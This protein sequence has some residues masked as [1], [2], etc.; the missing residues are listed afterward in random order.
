MEQRLR[1]VQGGQARSD[2]RM[3]DRRRLAVPGQIV[4]KDARGTTRMAAVVTRDVSENGVS[5]DCLGGMPIPL[6][7][8]VYFQIDREARNRPDLPAALRK[9]SVLSAIFRVGACKQSTGAPSEYALRM[10]VEPE[11]VVAAKP[12]VIEP[13]ETRTA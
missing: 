12:V 4:W 13:Q 3:S 9:S 1:L 11:R 10:L 7:S 8:L 5:V 6:F 2:K